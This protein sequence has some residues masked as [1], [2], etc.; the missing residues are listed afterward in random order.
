MVLH[1]DMIGP[2]DTRALE[3]AD[4]VVERVQLGV[5]A[6]RVFVSHEEELRMVRAYLILRKALEGIANADATP[7][8]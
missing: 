3:S 1:S 2:A 4:R 7:D 6:G 8:G 5:R